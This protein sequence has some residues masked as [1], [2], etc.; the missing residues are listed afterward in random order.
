MKKK[1]TKEFTPMQQLYFEALKDGK[2]HT[3]EELLPIQP[4]PPARDSNIVHVH[5]MGLRKNLPRG[6]KIETTRGVGYKLISK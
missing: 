5:M 1:T 3:I 2:L 4:P 6:M